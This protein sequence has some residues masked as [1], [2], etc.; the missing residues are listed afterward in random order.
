MTKVDTIS[1]GAA[2]RKKDAPL[3]QE[4]R[5]S[6]I[7]GNRPPLEINTG[8]GDIRPVPGAEPDT[9]PTGAVGRPPK[10]DSDDKPVKQAPV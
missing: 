5:K 6:R 8:R 9:R 2:D 7:F 1:T 4:L 10:V 3:D